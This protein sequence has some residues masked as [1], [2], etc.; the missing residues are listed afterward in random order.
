MVQQFIVGHVGQPHGLEGFV[1][2]RS[3]SGEW[4][5][6]LSLKEILLRGKTGEKTCIIEEI[7]GNSGHILM[8]FRG[9]ETPE[10]ARA[11][12][13]AVL[14][15]GRDRAAPLAKNEYYIEDLKGL[16]VVS[17]GARDAL[18]SPEPAV[19]GTVS[20]VIEGG[21]GWLVEVKLL[22]G[23]THL[24][25]FRKEFFGDVDSENRTIP[26]LSEWILE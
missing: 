25:P 20:D 23:E 22:S 3:A 1:K 16:G 13:G 11:L 21:G 6:L 19:L 12:S 4:E 18:S 14:I 26:L 5:H 7:R 17:S 24:V 10:A 15:T 2:I 9:I 8:K